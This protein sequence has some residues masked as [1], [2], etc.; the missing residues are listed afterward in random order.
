MKTRTVLLGASTLILG[1]MTVAGTAVRSM[2]ADTGKAEAANSKAGAEAA[3]AQKA[4]LKRKAGDAVK[5]A[6]AA[7]ALDPRNAEYR[8]LLGQAYLLAGRF[9][10]ASQALHDTLALD[11]GNGRAA[12]NLAL[13]EIGTGDWA[14]ARATLDAHADQIPA[15]DLGLAFALAGDPARGVEILGNAVRQPEATAKTRQNL[16]LAFALAGRWAEATSVAAV[17]VPGDQLDQ[18]IAQWARFATPAN[19]YDQ[20]AALLGVKAVKD[21]GQPVALALAGTPTQVAVETAIQPLP[22]PAPEPKL[23]STG[24][25]VFAP[26]REIVQPLPATYKPRPIAPVR[27]MAAARLGPGPEAFYVQLGAF[28][29]AGVAKDAWTRLSRRTPALAVH[30]PQGATVRTGTGTFYRLS[31]GG[32]AREE[33]VALCGTVKAR[34]GACF[35]RRAAGDQ[36]ASWIASKDTQLAAR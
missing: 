36:T 15:S 26:R 12:L 5:A 27:A 22:E 34:G 8:S 33:A 31:V 16:A 10:S 21:G 20:V 29:N 11:P 14:G 19:A 18:R 4:L 24:E 32:F 35:V 28:A 23:A 25:V 1:A 3:R 30:M 2:S 9:T 6:E 7:V 13:A 17:D